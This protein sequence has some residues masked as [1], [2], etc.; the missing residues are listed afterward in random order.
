MREVIHD[1]FLDITGTK[2][3]DEQINYIK[4][5]LPSEIHLQAEQWGW[6]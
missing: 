4:N 3:D 6:S 1:C 5:I 2:P